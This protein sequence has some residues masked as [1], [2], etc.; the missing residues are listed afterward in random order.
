MLIKLM[1]L[2]TA[3]AAVTATATGVATNTANEK[4]S[5][6]RKATKAEPLPEQ[7]LELPEERG[8]YLNDPTARKYKMDYMYV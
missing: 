1:L 6:F 2:A 8:A 7:A 5:K 3:A 4:R